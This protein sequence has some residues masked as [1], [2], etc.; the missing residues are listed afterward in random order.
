MDVSTL[1]IGV[2]FDRVKPAHAALS[3]PAKSAYVSVD[4]IS[5]QPIN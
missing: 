2:V 4:K 1:A 5:P 3:I